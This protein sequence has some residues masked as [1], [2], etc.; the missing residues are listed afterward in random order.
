MILLLF[1]LFLVIVK[2]ENDVNNVLDQILL[3]GIQ[4][5]TYPAVTGRIVN[6]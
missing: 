1:Y 5:S 4:D 6:N 2:G 3:Q